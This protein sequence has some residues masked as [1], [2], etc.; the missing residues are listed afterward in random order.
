MRGPPATTTHLATAAHAKSYLASCMGGIG[1]QC[2]PSSTDN[3]SHDD[4]NPWALPPRTAKRP[5][6]N[7]HPQQPSRPTV[8]AGSSLQVDVAPSAPC[9]GGGG[10]SS[11]SADVSRM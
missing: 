1:C 7:T 10:G 6:L 11:T 4:K 9:T 3:T 5:S 2:S 8:I